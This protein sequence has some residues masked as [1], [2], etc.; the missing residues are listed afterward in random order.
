MTCVCVVWQGFSLES[1]HDLFFPLY[2]F[3]RQL[4]GIKDFYL[5]RLSWSKIRI[6]G[7]IL[8][9]PFGFF[10]LFHF[11]MTQ[12]LLYR[13]CVVLFGVLS[14]KTRSWMIW[15][16]SMKVKHNHTIQKQLYKYRRMQWNISES[17]VQLYQAVCF[18]RYWCDRRVA[19]TS[20]CH[21][22]IAPKVGTDLCWR[23]P[24]Y[25]RESTRSVYKTYYLR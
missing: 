1:R 25:F 10:I 5:C 20:F 17:E 15:R 16:Q 24:S 2:I 14:L 6:Q 11:P 13:G 8:K 19:T 23:L 9:S 18:Q 22:L 7:D 21:Y 12:K 3:G 4:I